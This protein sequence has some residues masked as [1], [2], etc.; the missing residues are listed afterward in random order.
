MMNALQPWE[1]ALPDLGIEK[2]LTSP[3]GTSTMVTRHA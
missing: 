1:K 3:P 2:Y